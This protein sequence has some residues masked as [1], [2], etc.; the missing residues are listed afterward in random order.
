MIGEPCTFHVYI[1]L[2]FEFSDISNLMNC[3]D[4]YGLT[5]YYCHQMVLFLPGKNLRWCA[6]KQ[7]VYLLPKVEIAAIIM[8]YRFRHD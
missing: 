3:G 5:A 4:T 2:K 1:N 6:V 7:L 8:S